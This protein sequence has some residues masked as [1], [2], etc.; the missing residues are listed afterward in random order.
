MQMPFRNEQNLPKKRMD[1]L[2]SSCK[3]YHVIFDKIAVKINSTIQNLAP[4][5]ERTSQSAA[6]A[7]MQFCE[8][9]VQIG[10]Y[11]AYANNANKRI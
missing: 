6:V 4:S 8:F 2:V 9:S 5:N 3:T 10:K 1:C 7:I 11:S